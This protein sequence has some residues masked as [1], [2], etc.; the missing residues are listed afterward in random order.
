MLKVGE[1]ISPREA[2]LKASLYVLV[3][4]EGGLGR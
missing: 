2:I 4:V 1:S 3:D